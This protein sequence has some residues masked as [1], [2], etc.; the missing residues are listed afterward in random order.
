MV[1]ALAIVA[2]LVAA[3]A[4]QGAPTGG[5]DDRRPPGVVS[6][7][8]DTFAVLPKFSAQIRFDFDERISERAAGGSLDDAVVV[9]PR[10]AGLRVRH[11]RRSLVIDVDGGL[12]PDRVYRVTLLPVVSDLFGNQMTDPFE[13]VFSTG[14]APVPTTIA[15]IIWDRVTGRGVADYEVRAVATVGDSAQ[16]L[17]MTDEAGV[18][19]LRFLPATID[20]AQGRAGRFQL[21]A[22]DDRNRDGAVGPMEVQG[23]RVGLV[24][25]ADTLYLDIAVLQPDTTPAQ[26]TS[27]TALDSVTVLIELDDYL[28][29]D[30][31]L[32]GVTVT[33]L[34]E[35]SVGVSVGSVFHE[36]E[37]V[38]Y[39]EAVADSFAVLDSM[40]AAVRDAVAAEA[41]AEAA[42]LD[43]AAAEVGAQDST[44]IEE[45]EDVL[46]SDTV[47]ITDPAV[48]PSV[49]DSVESGQEDPALP[50]RVAPSALD[51]RPTAR[52][53]PPAPG[54]TPPRGQAGP[55]G[56]RL[57]S[58]QIV[59]VLAEPL[60][61]NSPYELVVGAVR[62]IT[63]VPL[64]GGSAALV[65]QPPE[66]P[67]DSA[68]VADSVVVPDSASGSDSVVVPDTGVAP[69]VTAVP[70]TTVVPDTSLVSLTGVAPDRARR[71]ASR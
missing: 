53:G 6:T 64:G 7:T 59:A 58:R 48:D 18:F 38:A 65:L 19:A 26:I 2:G 66:Q 15:G 69:G 33:V 17:A 9:S 60:V 71:P 22:F 40:D 45:P 70:D 25:E 29:P 47:T 32:A 52:P 5:P 41:A 24:P 39:A 49:E 1:F 20:G 21:T 51:G 37:Y 57:P 34:D 61:T 14:P 8:P 30:L 55:A 11:E 23:A 50:R 28:D 12:E 36:H 44:T 54:A 27:V 68:S 67:A 63:S 4:Q 3:C 46:V 56:Q 16:Y 31:P 62:N 43:S 42:A 10:P 35:D 13:L